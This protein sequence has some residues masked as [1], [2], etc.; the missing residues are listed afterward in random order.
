[1]KTYV[2]T[3]W[4]S[5]PWRGATCGPSG[6]GGS[7]R[8][9]CPPSRACTGTSVDSSRPRGTPEAV[10]VYPHRRHRIYL[11]GLVGVVR[12]LSYVL[13]LNGLVGVVHLMCYMLVCLYAVHLTAVSACVHSSIQL[14]ARV[15]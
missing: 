14:C 6:R 8:S 2:Y 9:C 3:R 7:S 15:L 11:N 13:C 5:Q 10:E 1:M 12:F 4:G